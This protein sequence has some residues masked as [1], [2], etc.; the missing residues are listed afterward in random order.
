LNTL[1]RFASRVNDLA[2]KYRVCV[3]PS[4]SKEREELEPVT[5][6]I[7]IKF[8]NQHLITLALS[9]GENST[10]GVDYKTGTVEANATLIA[11][12]VWHDDKQ[13]IRDCVTNDGLSPKWLGV[14]V[15]MIWF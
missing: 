11:P 15:R 14:K 8:G 9:A 6:L 10:V 12:S 3:G 5:A 7:Q 4:G 13:T 2:S 1:A